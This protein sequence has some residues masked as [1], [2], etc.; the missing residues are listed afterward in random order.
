VNRCQVSIQ[1]LR[2]RQALNGAEKG[3]S[4]GAAGKVEEALVEV[5][6]Q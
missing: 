6:T 3:K 4:G 1:C 5:E 2:W